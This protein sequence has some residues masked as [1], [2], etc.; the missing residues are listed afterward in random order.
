MKTSTLFF[1]VLILLY[2][3]LFAQTFT[4]IT[5]GSMV[6]DGGVSYGLAWGDYDNDGFIDLFVANGGDTDNFLYRND[7]DGTFAK[8]TTG[9]M[10]SDGGW[11]TSA[12][13]GDY[14]NDGYLD[15]R[16][17]AGQ[18]RPGNLWIYH[19]LPGNAGYHLFEYG[20]QNG[21]LFY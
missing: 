2:G 10:V 13:W 15:L 12:S 6:N 9:S 20:D 11:S 16:V 3:N 8:I 14:D 17:C 18:G 5:S 4:R 7:G 21:R 1:T 19:V